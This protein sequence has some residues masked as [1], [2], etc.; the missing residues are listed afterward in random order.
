[1][2]ARVIHQRLKRNN[3]RLPDGDH[4]NGSLLSFEL[5][6]SASVG[7][8]SVQSENEGND[9]M[10][11]IQKFHGRHLFT[12]SIVSPKRTSPFELASSFTESSHPKFI[13]SP[14]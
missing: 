1:M 3:Q 7:C 11:V 9:S 6:L 2:R 14:F 8:L 12:K 13:E 10:K 5:F 4:C